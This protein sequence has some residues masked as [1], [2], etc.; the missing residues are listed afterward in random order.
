MQ[1][2]RGSKYS[3]I[4]AAYIQR[5]GTA[6]LRQSRGYPRTIEPKALILLLPPV[7]LEVAGDSKYSQMFRNCAIDGR[8]FPEEMPWI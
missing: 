2:F 3:G 1:L 4:A 8:A 6:G 5:D 7:P